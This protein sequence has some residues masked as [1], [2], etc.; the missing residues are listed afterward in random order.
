MSQGFGQGSI[1][2]KKSDRH[3][4]KHI[5]VASIGD[6]QQSLIKHFG[7]IEDPRVERTKKH[8]LREMKSDCYSGNNCRSARLGRH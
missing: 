5:E 8:L 4:R 7:D 2:A 3:Q 6:I 1:D